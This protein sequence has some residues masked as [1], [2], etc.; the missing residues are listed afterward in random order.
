MSPSSFGRR[1]LSFSGSAGDRVA[2]DR[3]AGHAA[4][5]AVERRVQRTARRELDHRHVAI[6]LRRHRPDVGATRGLDDD[7]VVRVDER[8]PGLIGDE[9]VRVGVAIGHVD[10]RH[11][12]DGRVGGV[13]PAVCRV[14]RAVGVEADGV[15]VG[16]TAVGRTRPRRLR[17]T[18]DDDLAVG[19][20]EGASSDLLGAGRR[21]RE[22][23]VGVGR[24]LGEGAGPDVD[25]G[26]AVVA[27]LQVARAI[28]T[29]LGDGEELVGRAGDRRE[30]DGVER[31]A[32][33]GG[34]A[35]EAVS[36]GRRHGDGRDTAHAVGRIK[37]CLSRAG[38]R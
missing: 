27:E 26:D 32:G 3:D 24:R 19:L 36:R 12:R 9:R 23:A 8:A 28:G 37:A 1:A 17:L 7:G 34:R 38:S 25:L 29:E 14:E 2:G 15:D 35:E 10:P 18:G 33:A 13:R 4:R 5:A 11:T 16:V 20:N 31:A 22:R 21:R 30:A 6:D